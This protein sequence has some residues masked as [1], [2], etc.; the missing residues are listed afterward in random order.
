MEEKRT[1]RALS[2]YFMQV[3]LVLLAAMVL[4]AGLAHADG[5]APMGGLTYRVGTQGLDAQRLYADWAATCSQTAVGTWHF[6]NGGH[7]TFEASTPGIH[8][9]TLAAD[10]GEQVVSFQVV[11]WDEV[12]TA[13]NCVLSCEEVRDLADCH[14]YISLCE[15][16]AI[17]LDGSGS[18]PTYIMTVD[19][20][21]ISAVPGR[22]PIFFKTARGSSASAMVTVA[23]D[24]LRVI[25]DGNVPLS[26]DIVVED[27]AAELEGMT[28]EE[29]VEV[30]NQPDAMSH[31]ANSEAA[32]L[33]HGDPFQE[34]DIAGEQ[35]GDATDSST[36]A[37][38]EADA[39]PA[40]G[41]I[42]DA[43]VPS[44]PAVPE[45][46]P[47]WMAVSEETEP[48][49]TEA[50][51]EE[52]IL[53][54]TVQLTDEDGTVIATM[55]IPEG[56][57]T[58]NILIMPQREGYTFLGWYVKGGQPENLYDAHAPVT[59]DLVLVAAYALEETEETEADAPE[60][61]AGMDAQASLLEAED[62]VP[63]EM[64]E[65]GGAA[66]PAIEPYVT[67]SML[68]EG[69]LTLG[70]AV[71]LIATPHEV[72]EGVEVA[73]QWQSD[74]TGTFED[75]PGATALTYTFHVDAE[76]AQCQWRL[77]LTITPQEAAQAEPTPE[78]S[79]PIASA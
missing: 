9:I 17:Y 40:D 55:S 75:I 8:Q 27:V 76:N 62:T 24:E 58:G 1:R 52:P 32:D 50:P 14:T 64:A 56:D 29:I 38:P 43:P 6:S 33:R 41:T 47:D 3:A 23:R 49:A 21:A 61:E 70:T 28:E 36:G 59:N 31:A 74:L 2:R 10:E 57:A 35:A 46:L 4:A 12:V 72:P 69:D 37:T 42:T 60:G 54:Y 45:T 77:L 30:I 78:A 19:A 44:D 73:Y 66:E 68:Y 48:E 16:T 53:E 51:E 7:G 20:S 13:T 22:Y 65:E 5:T 25:A 79:E 63:D 39:E 67:L 34:I 11:V 18:V 15:A 71:T 26:G